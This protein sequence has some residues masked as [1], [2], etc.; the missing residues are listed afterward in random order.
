MKNYHYFEMS[1]AVMNHSE[2][3]RA[4]HKASPSMR[5]SMLKASDCGLVHSICECIDNTIRGNT[6]LTSAQKTRLSRHKKLL[7]KIVSRG[8]SWKK[9][10]KLLVQKGG[11]ILPLILGPLLGGVLSSLFN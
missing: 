6:K 5:T 3:L 7:R 11:A 4:L 2:L 9:R 1:K 10:K 8:Q